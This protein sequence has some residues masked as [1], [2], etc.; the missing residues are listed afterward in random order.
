[1][2]LTLPYPP[3]AN[4]MWRNYNGRT[5]LSEAARNY[6]LEVGL[7]NLHCTPY[8][9]PVSVTLHIYRPRKVSDLDNRIKVAIDSVQGIAFEDDK[10]IVQIHAYRHD[11]KLNPRVEMT[12]EEVAA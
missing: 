8:K 3:S 6:K 12:I 11:D 1:M 4:V 10:Q 5:V 9:G 2:Q 7:T